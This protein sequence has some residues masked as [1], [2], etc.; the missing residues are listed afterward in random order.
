MSPSGFLGLISGIIFLGF[1]SDIAFKRWGIPPTL[2]IPL[3]GFALTELLRLFDPDTIMIFVPY[4]GAMAFAIILF[5]GGIAMDL[6]SL[7]RKVATATLFSILTFTLTV[8]LITGIWSL[9]GGEPLIGML[10]GSI[11]GGTSGAIVIPLISKMDVSE[12][13]KTILKMESV[14]TDIF[15]I[16]VASI[17]IG[18][19][20][21]GGTFNLASYLFNSAVNSIILA[22]LAGLAW[23]EMV[24][25]VSKNEV[26]Y[27]LL[28]AIL[29]GL[30]WISELIG[31]SGPLSA[32]IFGVT[33]SNLEKVVN[34]VLPFLRINKEIIKVANLSLDNFTRQISSEISFVF[35]T[36]F[37]LMIG[38]V[39]KKEYILNWEIISAVFGFFLLII[40]SR[41]IST[42]LL[43]LRD[44]DTS[45]RDAFAIFFMMPRGLAAAIMAINAASEIPT[46]SKLFVS[47]AFGIILITV[48]TTTFGEFL[49]TKLRK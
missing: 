31:A 18:I 14:L 25:Y 38:M 28:L 4:F 7:F 22:V 40:L 37:F 12:E 11:V 8:I 43:Y 45:L 41:A 27:I 29:F 17:A 49:V 19:A 44:R 23:F 15:V 42:F 24:K 2:I 1:F 21:G 13:A 5:E 33:L 20:K 34:R 46:Y 48:L 36:F 6:Y 32:L 3:F 35:T 39:M 10:I 26:Y 47:Y 9:F 30:Y 16:M